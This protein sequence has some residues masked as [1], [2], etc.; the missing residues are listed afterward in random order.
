MAYGECVKGGRFFS[1]DCSRATRIASLSVLLTHLIDLSTPL[2]ALKSNSFPRFGSFLNFRNNVIHCLT[3]API[4]RI[5]NIG[6][7]S[8]FLYD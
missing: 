1:A 5:S 6:L 7:I 8:C 3:L 2:D 4:S